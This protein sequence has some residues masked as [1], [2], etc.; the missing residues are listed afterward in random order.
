MALFTQKIYR[1]QN[2]ISLLR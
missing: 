2:M 1:F